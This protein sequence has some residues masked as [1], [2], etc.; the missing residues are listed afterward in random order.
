[1]SLGGDDGP[2][3]VSSSGWSGGGLGPGSG[4]AMI[5]SSSESVN[6]GEF[7]ACSCGGGSSDGS[8]SFSRMGCVGCR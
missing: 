8:G 6:G 7:D 4:S 3:V 2:G 1:M 5:G